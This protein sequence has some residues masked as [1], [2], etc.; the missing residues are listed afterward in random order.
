MKVSAVVEGG[1]SEKSDKARL[2]G[3]AGPKKKVDVMRRA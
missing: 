3:E 1:G 2:L